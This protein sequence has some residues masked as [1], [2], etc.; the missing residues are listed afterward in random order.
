MT[1]NK[2][3]TDA[4]APINLV[5]ED[6][7]YVTFLD[8][9]GPQGTTEIGQYGQ[10]VYIPPPAAEIERYTRTR[11]LLD[12][13]SGHGDTAQCDHCGNYIRYAAILRH[14][15]S[16]EHIS[17][18]EQCLDNRFSRATDDFQAA[19]KGAA[20]DRAQQRIKKLVA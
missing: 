9:R 2:A 20:L 4:H 6:Y 18:G 1:S 3:R 17:V 16:G 13:N 14:R 12:G 8:F 7:D 11:A 19:R 5:T 10:G 15:V